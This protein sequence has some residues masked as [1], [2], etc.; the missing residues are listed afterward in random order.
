MIYV[1]FLVAALLAGFFLYKKPNKGVV[2][3]FPQGWLELL[4]DNVHFY[5]E[6]PAERQPEFR[7]RMMLF[8]S[9]VY[10]EGV[11]I[12]ITDL[13]KILIACSAVIPVFGFK[14]WHYYNLSGILLYPDYF[15]NDLEFADTAASRNIGGLV[16]S[17][18]FEKQMILSRR[19]LHH[20]FS[21]TT[22]KSNTG[23]HEFVHLID[24][25]DGATDG[26]P[27]QLLQKQYILPWLDLM[28]KTMEEIN[29]DKSDIREYGG[30][31]QAEFFAVVSE[32]FFERPDLL[33]AKHPELYKML[34]ACFN[35]QG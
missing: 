12:E 19:A 8:L 20:G 32:Y 31:N 1:I 29:D 25:M 14:E 3:A 23:I 24:K 11:E 21:N 33:E 2:E 10:I 16:G 15:N 35:P 6:L 18:R 22:D 7:Q 9:E 4:Q 34:H 30:T 26:I 27:E 17:G 5:R 13:D 28:H